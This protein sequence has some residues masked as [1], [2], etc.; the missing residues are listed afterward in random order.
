MKNKECDIIKDLLPSY[1]DNICSEAS[2]EWIEEHIAECG[3][4]RGVA[5]VMKHIEISAARLEQEQLEAGNRALERATCG[6]T[7]L[8]MIR[9]DDEEAQKVA[10]EAGYRCLQPELDRSSY[11]LHGANNAT[12]L[13]QR[14]RTRGGN[15][16]VWLADTADAVGLRAFLSSMEA[17]EGRCLAWTETA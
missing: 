5:E 1:V 12:N 3:D 2:K 17:I 4:C 13:L 11:V 9:G 10:E 8:V 16:T 6:G 14:I 7:R 15:V